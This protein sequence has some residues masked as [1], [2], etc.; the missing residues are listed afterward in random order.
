MRSDK[1]QQTGYVRSSAARP[2]EIQSQRARGHDRDLKFAAQRS[3]A[4]F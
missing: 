3:D 4:L 1:I 2:P